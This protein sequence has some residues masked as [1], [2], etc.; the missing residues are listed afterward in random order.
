[1]VRWLVFTVLPLCE[2]Y[3]QPNDREEKKRTREKHRT[4]A[5]LID[6]SPAPTGVFL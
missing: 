2:L 5:D 1:M 6:E 4:I 3:R